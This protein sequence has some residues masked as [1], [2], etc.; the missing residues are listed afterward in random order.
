MEHLQVN[1]YFKLRNST[2]DCSFDSTRLLGRSLEDLLDLAIKTLDERTQK[3]RSL[4]RILYPADLVSVDETQ[5]EALDGF[6]TALE[7]LLGVT[8][9]SI[10]IGEIWAE[11][12]PDEASDENMQ[13]YMRHVGIQSRGFQLSNISGTFSFMVL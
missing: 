10:D 3:P 6:V 11:N 7:E 13:A 9:Q 1:G 4:Q 2:D 8:V 5:Q 12:P